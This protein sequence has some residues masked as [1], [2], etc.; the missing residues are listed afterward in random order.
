MRRQ[1]LKFSWKGTHKWLGIVFAVVMILFC[2]SGVILNHREL[3]RDINVRR[4]LLPPPYHIKDYNNG[5]IKGTVELHGDSVLAYGNSGLWLTDKDFSFFEDFN[6]GLPE[7]IDMRNIRNAVAAGGEVWCAAQYNVY[8]LEGNKWRA[9][10]LPGNRERISD[11]TLSPGGGVTVLTR[12]AL[13]RELPT[14]EFR[15]IP[16]AAPDGYEKLVTLFKTFW[17]FHS[18]ELF[19]VA[20][21]II[22]DAVALIVLFLCVSGLVLFLLPWRIRHVAAGKIKRLGACYKWNFRWHDKVGYATIVVTL[23]VAFT[24]M[25]LR[26]PLMVPLVL[27]TTPPPPHSS[28]DSDNPWHDKLR[29][30][31][32]DSGRQEWLLSTSE[33]F[34]TVDR[35]FG[36]PPEK[37]EGLI[38]P[39]SPMGVTVMEEA[40]PGRWLVGSFSG[41]F[42]WD[43][44]SG[45]ITDYFTGAPY[46]R[47]VAGRPISD[48]L[49]CGYS[50]PRDIVFHHYD[51]AEGMPAMPAALASQPMSLWNVALEVHSGRIYSFLLVPLA[52]LFIFLAGALLILV[53]VSGLV[54]HNRR[55]KRMR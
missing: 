19:G 26:P 36:K 3:V 16:L 32:W 55:R 48:R 39:V 9:V 31:R 20:G 11:I 44:N 5:I 25:C 49:V 34:F 35:D 46:L 10:E 13:Y 1:F 37:E 54:M 14:G 42:Y 6:A 12:S 8:R 4:A 2:V 30:I 41:M 47:K 52:D 21:K 38:P 18:G 43:R 23:V 22:I 51:G 27:A 24:G 28:L 15:K 40:A 53:L 33:G 45:K 29:A 50:M 7:S 17:H